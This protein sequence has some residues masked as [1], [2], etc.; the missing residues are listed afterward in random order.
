V[1]SSDW[2]VF[3]IYNTIV[4]ERRPDR[5]CNDAVEQVFPGT[6]GEKTILRLKRQY[7]NLYPERFD[8]TRN[9][10]EYFKIPITIAEEN[11]VISLKIL[12]VYE[13]DSEGGNLL[14]ANS[15]L[16]LHS[17]NRQLSLGSV[18]YFKNIQ[19]PVTTKF[20][21]STRKEL[22]KLANITGTNT[23]FT[24]LSILPPGSTI[25]SNNSIFLIKKTKLAYYVVSGYVN[26]G[27]QGFVY[28]KVINRKN[29]ETINSPQLVSTNVEY[30]GWSDN[31]DRKFNF[32]LAA[33]LRVGDDGP[34][35]YPGEFQLGFKPSD[36]SPDKILL[37]KAMSVEVDRR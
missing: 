13:K 6:Y 34:P 16:E 3:P 26:P 19:R 8:F 20:L 4:A 11:N 1:K 32:C 12:K 30:V 21:E 7:L 35:K 37:K 27:K 36:H 10:S 29:G 22:Q 15:D 31:P 33:Y 5:N 14:G 2:H 23:R 17:K 25:V 9:N 28:L 18:E 24:D